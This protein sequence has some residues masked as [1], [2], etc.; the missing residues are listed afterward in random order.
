MPDVATTP[1]KTRA[2]LAPPMRAL[3][4]LATLLVAGCLVPADPHDERH[5]DA[6]PTPS[7]TPRS[8][9][10]GQ[11][12][13]ELRS[14]S[15]EEIEGYRRG[16]GLGYAKPAELNSYPGPLHALEM[17]ERL[18]LTPEQRAALTTLREDMLEKAVPLGERYLVL[19]S[20]IEQGFRDGSLDAEGLRGLLEESALVEAELRFAHLEAHL[21]T[22]EL[23]TRHQI[24][25]YDEAR[26]YGDADHGSHEH[27]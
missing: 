14:L 12:A 22:R 8:P 4:L 21:A 16:A 7:S 3:A 6:T 26:G 27:P 9:Y 19:E 23:L 24:A 20:A 17:A 25:L 11:E 10:A 18:Q 15:P 5:A 2:P 13:R 1:F